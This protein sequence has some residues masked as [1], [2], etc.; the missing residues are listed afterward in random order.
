MSVDDFTWLK[1]KFPNEIAGLLAHRVFEQPPEPAPATEGI[2]DNMLTRLINDHEDPHCVID[3]CDVCATRHALEEL[4]RLRAAPEPADELTALR[5][6]ER[7]VRREHNA[8]CPEVCAYSA[9]LNALDALR[10]STTKE[11]K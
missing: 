6:L 4:Q 11:A 7:V 1:Q 2:S 3:D 10:L 5:E 8:S 9:P